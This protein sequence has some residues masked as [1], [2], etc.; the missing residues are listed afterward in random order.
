[1][2]STFGQ[3]KV[4]KL[5]PI[6]VFFTNSDSRLFRDALSPIRKDTQSAHAI[7]RYTH[8]T[9]IRCHPEAMYKEDTE[10]RCQT[11]HR[12]VKQ[13]AQLSHSIYISHFSVIFLPFTLTSYR[14]LLE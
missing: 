1:M 12:F 6:S 10:S 8:R 5:P 13:Q 9:M 7:W 14:V 3:L 11:M 2:D 4:V